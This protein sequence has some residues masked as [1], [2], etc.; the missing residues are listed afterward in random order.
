[1]SVIGA[2]AFSPDTAGGTDCRSR[3]TAEN[4]AAI[5][6]PRMA[7]ESERWSS[8][9]NETVP[10]RGI[11]SQESGDFARLQ[12]RAPRW[13]SRYDAAY[14]KRVLPAPSKR[15]PPSWTDS[16]IIVLGGGGR[17]R[18]A[19][20][21]P[22]G[23]ARQ[24]GRAFIEAGWLGGT[25]VN[26]GCV[27]KKIMW[28]AATLMESRSRTSRRV[29]DSTCPCSRVSTLVG[30]KK[31]RD[32]YVRFLNAI[33]AK[34]LEQ[35][36]VRRIDGYGRF[37]DAHTIDVDG[38]RFAADH[39]LVATGSRPMLPTIPGV[40][41]GS[42]SD[43]FFDLAELPERVAIFG[44][45]YVAVEFA[46][47]L[48]A[49]GATVSLLLRR[50][51]PLSD[52]D[53]TLRTAL[54]EHM[55]ASGIVIERRVEVTRVDRAA[56]GTRT[57]DVHDGTRRGPFDWVLFAIGREPNTSGIGLETAEIR[58]NTNGHVVVDDF[59]N[60][61]VQGVYAVGDVTGRVQLT[62]VAIAAGRR[63]ADRLFGGQPDARIDY[64]GV[65]TVIFSHPPIGTVG[66]GED[67]ARVKYGDRIKTYVRRFTSLHHALTDRKPKTTV[68][69][70]VVGPEERVVGI[71]V[72]GM[73]ADEMIQGFAVALRMGA[74]KA[75]LDRTIAIHP[76]AAE[77]LVTLR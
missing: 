51:E 64:E 55:E 42:T 54:V 38:K 77:E 17:G 43:G 62:P 37:V 22:R 66:L 59:Q 33:Y 34:N 49:L 36:G 32:D 40:E 9:G 12:A 25:C 68:K 8:R 16:T 3:T 56:D 60:T 7:V 46:G 24:E 70:V 1:M 58:T 2:V 53:S 21:A 35:E 23:G 20:G 75:D 15:E 11:A 5:V 44:A 65:P 4:S 57:L 61:N 31:G 48:R 41:H 19:V 45:G 39:V 30:L 74:T 52:F 18:G 26:V 67:E 63:L 14:R 28:S 73:G 27:P 13:L 10:C 76:T 69:L 6:R 50:D 72:I 47:I 29:T 71:H